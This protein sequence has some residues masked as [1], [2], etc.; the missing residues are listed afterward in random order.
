MVELNIPK[1]TKITN[2]IRLI[3][4]FLVFPTSLIK[5]PISEHNSTAKIPTGVYSKIIPDP[6]YT[7][8]AHKTPKQKSSILTVTLI[9]T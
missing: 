3:T 5:T 6:P 1:Y 2:K 9:N 8:S 4:I 7:L